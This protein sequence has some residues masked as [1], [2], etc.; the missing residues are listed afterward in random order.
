MT[1]ASNNFIG[2]FSGYGSSVSVMDLNAFLIGEIVATTT[3]TVDAGD[4]ITEFSPYL[5]AGITADTANIT[6]TTGS[7]GTA[8]AGIST[9]VNTINIT[10]GGSGGPDEDII[11]F[12]DYTGFAIGLLNSGAANMIIGAN[13]ATPVT[14]SGA[15]AAAD[16]IAGGVVFALT[17]SG[18][19]GTPSN[20]LET[21]V[22]VMDFETPNGGVFATDADSVTLG[23]VAFTGVNLAGGQITAA[24]GTLTV[25]DAMTI[26]GNLTL[27]ADDMSLGAAS[28]PGANTVTLRPVTAT[29]RP[30]S[31]GAEV[32]GSL[33]L[34]DDELD[35]IAAGT[36]QIGNATSGAITVAADITRSAATTIGLTSGGAIN[37]TTGSVNTGGGSL[38]L[39]PGSA[40]VGVAKTGNDIT[41]GN[42]LPTGLAFASGAKLNI[43]I[44]G[45]AA[46]VDHD[47]L[48]VNG[49][50][51]LA[52]ATLT[53]SGSYV[54]AASD[55]FMIVSN[56]SSG[57]TSGNFT[58]LLE[59]AVVNVNG[60]P[61]QIT[62]V[63]GSGNDVIL[64]PYTP[65][66]GGTLSATLS[67]GSL[68]VTDIDALGRN[69]VF[70]ISVS[71]SSLVIS[72]DN[73]QFTAASAS[74]GVLSNGNKT[75]TV[76]LSSVTVG[77]TV[78]GSG[79][80]DTFLAATSLGLASRPQPQRRRRQRHV[81]HGRAEDRPQCD[82][83]DC[84]CRRQPARYAAGLRRLGGRRGQHRFLGPAC[85]QHPGRVRHAR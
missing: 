6:S 72:D 28:A 5:G 53:L 43:A 60:T 83:E 65:P 69:N 27:I 55:S 10:S 7:V 39:T 71:G 66:T 80:D 34:T 82:H 50:V 46:D 61:K 76:P 15:D 38:T 25:S 45:T 35:L 78:N 18:G 70:S 20:P 17:G 73:E 24:T 68:I 44:G 57:P 31:L 22:N 30:I 14:E 11:A 84:H 36:L 67:A 56:T 3:V 26:T 19:A 75:L 85:D 29:T 49:A 2:H 52:G 47:Q 37:F 1:H 40:G 9:E 62:Y 48:S 8:V 64:L 13:G 63:G 74:A 23:Q 4:D 81:R 59:G 12:E 16:I 33:S 79:G 54:P 51:N 58:G 42:T 21:Q 77:L 32:G 41:T